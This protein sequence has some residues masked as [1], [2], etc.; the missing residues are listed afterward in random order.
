M[1]TVAY[2]L[3]SLFQ[4]RRGE[5]VWRHHGRWC[6]K[7]HHWQ[8]ASLLLVQCRVW[9]LD[10][11]F[12]HHSC[13][14]FQTTTARYRRCTRI[15]FRQDSLLEWIA[16]RRSLFVV[17]R[18][19]LLEPQQGCFLSMHCFPETLDNVGLALN[20]PLDLRHGRSELSIVCTHWQMDFVAAAAGDHC[21]SA[22]TDTDDHW[23][24]GPCHEHGSVLCLCLCMRVC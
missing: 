21:N 13:C 23:I 7:G 12:W 22:V 24:N 3:D 8:L 1:S 5:L 19:L 10:C 14:Q 17:S 20:G 6:S 18:L 4:R 16:L 2:I 9:S 15:F 11:C